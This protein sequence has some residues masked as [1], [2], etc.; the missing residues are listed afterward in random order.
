MGT[1]SGDGWIHVVVRVQVAGGTTVEREAFL[2]S[3]CMSYLD[4]PKM[5]L[6]AAV[7]ELEGGCLEAL[8]EAALEWYKAGCPLGEKES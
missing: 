5:T 3:P 6:D 8:H 4:D 2:E 1:D 7:T